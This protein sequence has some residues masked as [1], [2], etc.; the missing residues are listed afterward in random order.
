MAY[1]ISFEKGRASLAAVLLLAVGVFGVLAT[2]TANA[3]P[4]I[5][6]VVVQGITTTTATITWQTDV[7]SDT[8]VS[9]AAVGASD[10]LS[11]SDDALVTSHQITLTNLQPGTQYIFQANSAD[12]QG[13]NTAANGGYFTT[14][15]NN[16]ISPNPPAPVPPAPV[17]S[18][19]TGSAPAGLQYQAP[20]LKIAIY[21]TGTLAKENGIIYFLMGKDAVKVPFT[22]MDVFTAL[23]YKAQ[24]IKDLDLSA[25]RMPA[26]YF[27]NDKNMQ[28]PWGS[29]VQKN[30]VLYYV[31]ETGMIGIPSIEIFTANGF[32]P[33]MILPMNA[34]DEAVLQNMPV[35][36]PLELNDDRIL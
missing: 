10:P 25:F 28:H 12:A 26:T 34:A 8:Y 11:E 35:M 6:S 14:L 19:T 27:L 22:S 13:T 17:G 36:Y 29:V 18:G 33:D 3:D 7:P 5:T 31:H 1:T 30:G 21:P 20:P 9:Y 15:A 24:N 16:T 2:G 32:T 4:V 23:G